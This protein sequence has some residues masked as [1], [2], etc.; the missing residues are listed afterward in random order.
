MDYLNHQ[1]Y[2]YTIDYWN[3]WREDN[4]AGE[5]TL[6][7]FY[8][9]ELLPKE[10]E[11]RTLPEPCQTLAMLVGHSI[12]PLLQTVYWY[13]PNQI[14]LLLNEGYTALTK[15]EDGQHARVP[16]DIFGNVVNRAIEHLASRSCYKSDQTPGID[17]VTLKGEQPDH[18]FEGLL[19]NVGGSENLVI[20]M[21]GAKKSM[22]AGA[23]LYAA[24][25]G[26]KSLLR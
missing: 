18:V 7:A 3:K 9:D 11:G 21:T 13:R 25:T 26:K 24:F 8:I 20:D 22:V 12:E 16:A 2:W 23:F 1:L 17:Y 10:M 19:E 5:D 15:G 4:E 6:L 14:Y